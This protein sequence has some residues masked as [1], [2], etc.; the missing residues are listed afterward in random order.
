M[1][2]TIDHLICCMSEI[3][4][5]NFVGFW[6]S[7]VL[8]HRENSKLTKDVT[9][10]LDANEFILCLTF[11]KVFIDDKYRKYFNKSR[12]QIRAPPRIRAAFYLV[13]LTKIT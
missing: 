7:H 1:T 6:L 5:N 12:P 8:Y 13:N 3:Q 4:A 2:W 10:I 11:R 9:S